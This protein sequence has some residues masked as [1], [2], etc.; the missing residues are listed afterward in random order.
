MGLSYSMWENELFGGGLHPPSTFFP[1][2]GILYSSV[3]QLFLSLEEIPAGDDEEG[4]SGQPLSKRL[5]VEPE[6]K[7]EKRHKV[8]ED[9]IQKMQ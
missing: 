7:K 1:S 2:V 3:K 9:E 6:K 8:D 5:K 4:T